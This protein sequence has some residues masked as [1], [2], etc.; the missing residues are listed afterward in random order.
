MGKVGLISLGCSKNLVDS[1]VMLGLLKHSGFSITNSEEDADIVIINTCSFISSAREESIDTIGDIIS[2]GNKK[3]IVTGCMAQRYSEKLREMFDR[4]IDAIVGVDEHVRIVEICRAVLNGKGQLCC[5]SKSPKYLYDHETPRLISTPRHYAYV[6]IAEG[7][8]N[9]CTYCVIP[10]IRGRYRS[11]SIDS[12]VAEV[13]KLAGIGVKE[14]VLIAQDTTYFGKE[15]SSYNITDLLRKLVTIKGIEWIRVLYAHPAHIDDDFLQIIADEEKICSYIDLPLQHI[16]DKIL[17]RMGRDVTSYQIYKLIDHIRDKIPRVTMRTSLIVGFP[18]EGE[19][20]FQELITF[21]KYAEFDHLGAFAYS[22]EEGTEA[23]KLDGQVPESVKEER[24]DQIAE[25]HRKI[26]LRKRR[27]L[28]GQR[29]RVIVDSTETELP[30][31]RTQGQ[32]PEIDDVVFIIDE[33]ETVKEGDF[34]DVEILDVH[35]NYDLIGSVE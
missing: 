29:C 4:K 32:A 5:V 6:K 34:V 11:R 15:I 17:K 9:F 21:I 25:V 3:V 27:K 7:C 18:G 33:N 12:I 28:I 1:E 2:K 23:E 19:S 14:I 35:G 13:N 22:P 16:N 30:I 10:Q 24:L 26:A 31:G 20:E 8:D